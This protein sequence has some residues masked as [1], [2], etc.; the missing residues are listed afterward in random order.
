MLSFESDYIE[1]AHPLILDALVKSN[2]EALSGYGADRFTKSAK[3]KIAEACSCPDAQIAFI[4]GGTQTNQIVIDTMLRQFEGVAAAST[5]HVSVHEAGAIEYTGRKVLTLPSHNGKMDAAEL[6]KY[7]SDFYSDGNC[8]HMVFPGMAYISYPTEYGTL[9]SKKELTALSEVCRKYKIPLYMDGARLGY[10]LMSRE[11]DLTLSDIA[12]LCDVFYIGGT[13]VGALCGEAVVFTKNNMPAHFEH[14]IKKHGALLAKGRLNAIQFDTLFTDNLYF[15]LGKN[16]IDRAEELKSVFI[17]KGYK[18][19]IDSPTNQQ[20]VILENK[21]LKQLAENVKFSFWEKY[22]D[23]HTVVRFATSWATTS[24][25]ISEL[26]K[27][28]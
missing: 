25:K 20:F 18:F 10:G 2:M 1:G 3:T 19:F 28:L 22:D 16:A 14:L 9:Y 11:C 24:E 8:E 5:G 7:I 27:L 17:Q 13:K 26:E 15:T 23:S 21:K 6:D 4:T 12:R